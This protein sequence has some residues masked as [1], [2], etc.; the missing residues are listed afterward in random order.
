MILTPLVFLQEHLTVRV[1][2]LSNHKLSL[3][4]VYT[5]E[6]AVRIVVNAIWKKRFKWRLHHGVNRSKLMLF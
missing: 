5:S 1:V 4:G 2:P 6:Y 3:S